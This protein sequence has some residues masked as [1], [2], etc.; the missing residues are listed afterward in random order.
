MAIHLDEFKCQSCSLPS[1]REFDGFINLPRVTS[2][3]KPYPPGGRL[4]VCEECGLVQKIADE[5]WQQE[6]AKIYGDYDMYHQSTAN[7]QVIFDSVSGRPSGRC[8]VLARRLLSSNSLQQSGTLLDVGAGSGAMLT[9]FSAT[10]DSWK[11]FGL[12][13]DARKEASLKTIPRFE[14]LFTSPPE[15][16]V[17]K[18]DLISLIHS[19]E[20]FSS[21]LHMLENLRDRLAPSGRLFIEVNNVT[22]TPFDMIVADHLC[23]FSPR[24]LRHMLKHAGFDVEIAAIDWINKEISVL[25][26]ASDKQANKAKED[27]EG[28]IVATQEGI[29]WLQS[30]LEGSRVSALSKVFGIFG[31]SVAATWL[32]SSLGDSVQFFVDEDPGREGRTHLGRPI[33][34]PNQVPQPF[35]WLLSPKSPRPSNAA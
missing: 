35:T 8:E 2:D 3:S 20:H 1:L 26:I 27:A 4:F 29:V 12:D 19:L 7:D 24:S 14:K 5:R 9:A 32:A 13:L 33:L 18:F 11:L 22:K 21:P 15:Q 30:M 31:T 28:A 17:E 23:H 6:A 10:F 34:K 25:A 16:L